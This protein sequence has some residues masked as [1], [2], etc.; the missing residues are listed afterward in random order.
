MAEERERTYTSDQVA[1]I[2][3]RAIDRQSAAGSITHKDLAETAREMGVSPEHLEE[4]IVDE[5]VDRTLREEREAKR[6]KRVRGFWM[7]LATYVVT[8]AFLIAINLMA[9]GVLWFPWVLFG[10]GLML[11]LQGLRAFT[12]KEDPAETDRRRAHLKAKLL[13]ERRRREGGSIERGA[14]A[15]GDAVTQA[16]GSLLESAGEGLREIAEE[17][18]GPPRAPE[19]DRPAAEAP[20]VRVP[21]DAADPTRHRVATPGE[22]E[23]A[24]EDE[25][26]A[27]RAKKL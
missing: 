25:E 5:E 26:P 7:G 15:F 1:A 14:R 8:N 27:R 12:P 23:E 6:R 3:S 22:A 17:I 2:L 16:F 21:S 9:E 13:A 24:L 4:A 11:A 19:K 20:R 18:A 10:W